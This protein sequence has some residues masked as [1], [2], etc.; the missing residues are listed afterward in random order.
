MDKLQIMPQLPDN[1][2]EI[3]L[4]QPDSSLKLE[5]RL[6]HET[7]WLSQAQIAQLFGVDRSVISKHLG[8]IFSAGELDEDSTCAIFAHMGNVGKQQYQTKYYNLDGILSVGYRVNSIN[9]TDVHRRYCLS[10]WRIV[11]RLGQKMVC[12]LENGIG[13]KCVIANNCLNKNI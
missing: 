11:E 5:V 4:Y 12:V 1:K 7:V 13:S 6:E 3:I 8:N 10:F 2:G 9:A